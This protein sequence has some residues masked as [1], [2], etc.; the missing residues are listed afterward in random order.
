MNESTFG[1]SE[2]VTNELFTSKI[3]DDGLRFTLS[4]CSSYKDINWSE[5]YFESCETRVN[6]TSFKKLEKI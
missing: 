6:E 2:F 5:W 3:D 4:S 1:Y